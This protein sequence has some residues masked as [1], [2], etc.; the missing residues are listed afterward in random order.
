MKTAQK[1]YQ[2]LHEGSQ[3]HMAGKSGRL[4]G[5][6][7]TAMSEQKTRQFGSGSNMGGLDRLI[8]MIGGTALIATG[9]QRRSWD[10]TLLSALGSVLVLRGLSGSSPLY[11]ALGINTAEEI[12]IQKGAKGIKVEKSMTID[13]SPDELYQFWRNFENL[14]RFMRHLKSVKILDQKR[15]HWVVKA[16]A[17]TTVEWDAE[18]IKEEENHMIAWRSLANA[19]VKNAGSVYFEQDTGGH[20]TLVRVILNYEPPAGR[21]GAVVARFFG[22]EPSRQIGDDLNRFKKIMEMDASYDKGVTGFA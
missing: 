20:G 21:I 2:S 1:F 19:E 6:K 4:S 7:N 10:G 8:S 11:Q 5:T 9:L 22:E 17:G 14:P 12:G 15:S 16:P 13:K 3:K 18:I